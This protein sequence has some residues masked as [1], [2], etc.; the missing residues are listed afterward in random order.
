M[1]LMEKAFVLNCVSKGIQENLM[2]LVL[3]LGSII[4]FIC[5]SSL[6]SG[7]RGRGTLNHS[8]HHV[9]D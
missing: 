7:P 8:L 4:Q 2:S 6:S 3:K 9:S 1:E 5:Q